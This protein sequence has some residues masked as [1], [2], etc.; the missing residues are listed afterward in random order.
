[1]FENVPVSGQNR[2]RTKPLGLNFINTGLGFVLFCSRRVFR[3]VDDIFAWAFCFLDAEN[4]DQSAFERNGSIKT[5]ISTNG[6]ALRLYK[7]KS[8]R[9]RLN[10]DKTNRKVCCKDKRAIGVCLRTTCSHFVALCLLMYFACRPPGGVTMADIVRR[11]ALVA[12]TLEMN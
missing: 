11:L 12:K 2:L 10:E 8:G 1:M 6:I 3:V 7:D 5:R 9:L 4:P